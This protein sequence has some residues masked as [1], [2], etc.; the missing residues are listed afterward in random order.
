[1]SN[2][3]GCKPSKGQ[4]T[5]IATAS[6]GMCAAAGPIGFAATAVGATIGVCVA[7][8]LGYDEASGAGEGTRSS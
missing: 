8:A 7:N 5:A 2:I 1:M 6:A 4:W 3:K